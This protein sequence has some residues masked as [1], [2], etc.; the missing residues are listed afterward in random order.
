MTLACK[1]QAEA[2]TERG[3]HRLRAVN[4]FGHSNGATSCLDRN[5]DLCG[6]NGTHRSD[7]EERRRPRRVV[8]VDAVGF[9][10]EH[11]EHFHDRAGAHQRRATQ[12]L[13]LRSKQRVRGQVQDAGEEIGGGLRL[14]SQSECVRRTDRAADPIAGPRAQASRRRERVRGRRVASPSLGRDRGL[15]EVARHLLV[16]PC[17]RRREVPCDAILLGLIE[18]LR[19]RPVRAAPLDGIG[20]VVDR[21]AQQGM[22]EV[23]AARVHRDQSLAL[24][25]LERGHLEAEAGQRTPDL[26]RLA[27]VARRGEEQG[28]PRLLRQRLQPLRERPLEGGAGGDRLDDR[29]RAVELGVGE[30]RKDLV[31]RQRVPAR[32]HDE[33]I[34]NT[35]AHRS[36]GPGGELGRGIGRKSPELETLDPGRRQPRSVADRQEEDHALA[37]QPATGEQERLAGWRVQPVRVVDHGE[38]RPLLGSGREQADGCRRG[39]E[40]VARGRR[41][42]GEGAR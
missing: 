12:L 8:C 35:R 39:G 24:R 29:R 6:S 9:L 32:L 41:S 22:E 18:D 10:D 7:G 15:L 42:E 3:E 4:G 26:A 5:C 14:P 28:A 37:P 11:G 2:E 34:A 33:A 20:D 19:E 25:G 31:Q 38:H 27:R 23:D 17:G 13:H 36:S 16:R 1:R 30:R 21:R 40:P